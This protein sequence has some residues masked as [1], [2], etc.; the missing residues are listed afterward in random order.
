MNERWPS[1]MAH[2]EIS[3]ESFE[4]LVEVVTEVRSTVSSLKGLGAGRE[5]FGIL[6]GKDGLVEDNL[7]LLQFLSRVESIAATNGVP[8]G[9]RLALANHELYLDV[10]EGLVAKYRGELET[11][12]LA[13]GRE[14]DGLNARLLNPNYVEKAPAGLVRET[15]MAIAEKQRLIERLKGQLEVI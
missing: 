15:R 4:R 9:L 7:L 13:V 6:Y 2:D 14:L 8:R 3:A 5:K 11:K 1:H 12:I 10:S